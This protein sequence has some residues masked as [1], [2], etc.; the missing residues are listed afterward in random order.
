[1][2]VDI[3][4]IR[5]ALSADARPFL[6]TKLMALA[7]SGETAS[8][9]GLH[10]LLVQVCRALQASQS[11]WLYASIDNREPASTLFARAD[12]DSLALDAR[13]VFTD[14][15]IREANGNRAEGPKTG[16]KGSRERDGEGVIVV[17][18]VVAAKC[19]ITDVTKLQPSRVRALLEELA[20]MSFES[21]SALE[22]S[23]MPAEE[24]DLVSTAAVEKLFPK[25]IKLPGVVGGHRICGFCKGPHTAELAKCPH[26]GAPVPQEAAPR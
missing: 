20:R 23:W 17:T 16:L 6:Q 4:R 7:Q 25:M 21:F 19:V 26:C 3:T 10:R 15:V 1:M 12:F 9:R 13:A 24:G 8:K 18:L 5:I 2:N 22:V 11:A 14:E